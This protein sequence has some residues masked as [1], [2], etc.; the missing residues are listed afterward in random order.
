MRARTRHPE[1]AIELVMKRALARAAKPLAPVFE[2]R[3][4]LNEQREGRWTEIRGRARTVEEARDRIR[5][6]FARDHE[7][8][9]RSGQ[10]ALVAWETVP[11][12]SS[13]AVPGA[14]SSA[15]PPTPTRLRELPHGDLPARAGEPLDGAGLFDELEEV[16]DPATGLVMRFLPRVDEPVVVEDDDPAD[17]NEGPD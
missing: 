15:P 16:V 17:A 1:E 7:D 13:S 10:L 2:I 8:K 6:L 11:G 12:T 4:F 14:S 5:A 3:M 9:Y